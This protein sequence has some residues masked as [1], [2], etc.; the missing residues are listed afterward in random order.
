MKRLSKW[1]LMLAVFS[2]IAAACGE[3]DT[4]TTSEDVAAETTTTE[5]ATATTEPAETTTTEAPEPEGPRTIIIGSTDTIAGLDSAD[6]YAVHDWELIRNTGE[7]LLGFAPGT[8]DLENALAADW[9]VSDDGLVYTFVLRDDIVYGDGTALTAEMY[10]NHITR[11]LTLDGSG[12]VGGA[13]GT[14]FIAD[15]QATDDLTVEITLT[16][17]FGY[18]PQVVTGAPYMPMHPD[19]EIDTLYEFPEAPIYGV[20]PWVITDYVIGEQTVLEPNEFY[21]GDAPNVD[22]IIIRYFNDAPTMAKA[23]QAGE[24]DIAWRTIAQPDLLTELEETD[25][26]T[27]ATVPGG[28]I[29]YMIINHSVA[30]TDNADV[31]RAIAALID[32]DEISDRVFA[33]TVEPLYSPIPPGFL[34]ANDVF[35]DVYAGPDIDA[36]QGFLTAA[37]YSETNKLQ[38]PIAYPPEHYGGTVSDMITLMSE[39]LEASGMIEVELIAQ[40]WSTYIGAVIA[41]EDYAVS[42]LGWFFDYPDPDNYLAPFVLNGGLGTM[43]TDPDTGAGID[44]DSQALV[45]LLVEAGVETD[46]DARAALYGQVQD[47]YADLVVTLPLYFEPEHVI[48]WDYISASDAEGAVES[49]NIGPTFDLRYSLLDSSK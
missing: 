28:G 21:Y 34:G 22:R 42:L 24:I 49:L 6:A 1:V 4:T 8:T 45:D 23:V 7:G 17:P 16:E 19:Y 5:A 47:L 36:A 37:G 44:A 39:Q 26:L 33:G 15:Y 43:I 29:R 40:E 20:G 31:R 3:G 25:G 38:L 14:P 48:Y 35:D 32:R 2:L 9:S 41:G 13:L 30:P 11:M 18:F 10:V 12:G 27:V 46:L